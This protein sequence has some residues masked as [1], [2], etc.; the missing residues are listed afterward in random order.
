MILDD[1]AS[2]PTRDGKPLRQTLSL[3]TLGCGSQDTLAWQRVLLDSGAVSALTL[4]APVADEGT[5]ALVFSRDSLFNA[6]VVLRGRAVY[7]L[8]TDA[9][10]IATR[11]LR[12]WADEREEVL[13]TYDRRLLGSVVRWE[14][15]DT[16]RVGKYIRPTKLRPEG[17]VPWFLSSAYGGSFPPDSARQA[18]LFEHDGVMYEWR[19]DIMGKMAVR[20]LPLRSRRALAHARTQCYLE[21][22]PMVAPIAWYNRMKRT[23]EADRPV[24]RPAAMCMR[25]YAA[26]SPLRDALLV[27]WMIVSE[28]ARTWPYNVTT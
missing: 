5:A 27:T 11:V 1:P 13:C 7:R 8:R 10:G 17:C 6:T 15:G 4:V 19:I 26:L 21:G 25:E 2:K 16:V 3:T 12:V 24:I 18:A 20:P 9:R 14:G 22:A 28:T 23:T